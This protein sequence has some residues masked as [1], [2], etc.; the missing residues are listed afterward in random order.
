VP[1]DTIRILQPIF[2]ELDNI[3]EGID[4][5]EFITAAERLYDIL[6]S[7]SRSLLIQTFKQ[8]QSSYLPEH[9]RYSFH[10]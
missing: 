3:E 1:V 7:N 4:Q 10:P 5:N 6:D 2:E 9:E 8:K